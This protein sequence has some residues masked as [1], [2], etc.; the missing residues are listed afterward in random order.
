MKKIIIYSIF[1]CLI[2]FI[3]RNWFSASLITG[4]DLSILYKSQLL[5]KSVHLFAWETAQS[6]GLGGSITSL[7]WLYVMSNTPL[8]IL[9]RI[10]GPNYLLI[11]RF[12]YF[13]PFLIIGIVSA[14]FFAKKIFSSI[15]LSIF[16]ITIYLSNTYI[17]MLSGGGQVIIAY[18]YAFAPAVLYIFI[19]LYETALERDKKIQFFSQII[20]A[21]IS[22][23]LEILFDARIGYIMLATVMLYSVFI[24]LHRLR[25]RKSYSYIWT[26]HWLAIF[27]PIIIALFL[28]S[29]WLL[30]TILI[31]KNPVSEFG[32]AYSSID[33][34]KFFSFAKFE[35]TLSLLHPNWPENIFGKVS[36]MKAEFLIIPI[37]AFASLLFIKKENTLA[38][39]HILFFA[40]IGLMGAFLAKGANDPFGFVY[41]WLFKYFP[42]FAMFRDSTKWYTIVALSYSILIPY[43]ASN[44]YSWLKS[45]NKYFFKPN[46]INL[47]NIFAIVLTSYF[48]LLISPALF[49]QLGGTFRST[50]IPREYIKLE[51][52]LSTDK[53]F[54]RTFWIPRIQRLAYFSNNHP[55]IPAN[56][57]F[58]VNSPRE[59]INS[60]NKSETNNLL[61]L[62]SVRYIIVPYDSIGE[63]FLTDRKYDKNVYRKTINEINHISWLKKIDGFGKIGVYEIMNPKDHFWS[64][65]PNLKINYSYIN[66]TKYQLN[67]NSSKAGDLLVFSESF[68][69]NW[70]AKSAD[71]KLVI[72]SVKYHGKYNSFLLPKDGNYNLEAY[73]T[74]QKWVN[75]GVI[76]S[77]MSLILICGSLIIL[78]RQK[79]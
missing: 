74:P 78:K 1:G 71:G 64:P 70:V 41:I 28:H 76:I 51:R 2:L 62:A 9:T 22:M 42:G 52:F 67:V 37:L 21:G 69:K 56:D 47:Q 20:L 4:S 60:L 31:G 43:S 49:G 34:V 17:L 24:A 19:K 46:I 63:L 14:F 3:F 65:Q 35:N 26:A 66:P 53:R 7:L 30:P 12:A 40:L 15:A 48:L 11:E 33:A 55:A 77:S 27:L 32:A 45:K 39:R 36:F 23:A 10:F 25:N 13:Y 75:I 50:R 73:Y 68:D 8:V 16:S 61:S 44:I 5:H 57:F 58:K 79:Q 54:Y 38:K 59:D 72:P 29:F 18:A 6:S